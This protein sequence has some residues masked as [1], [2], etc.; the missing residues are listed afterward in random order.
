[1][2]KLDETRRKASTFDA[3]GE[4]YDMDTAL[5]A[6]LTQDTTGHWP[7]RDPRTGMILK[8]R[9]HETFP[10]TEEGEEAAGYRIIKRGDRYYS[11][12]AGTRNQ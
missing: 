2:S 4:G 5:A 3:E 1:M 10:L 12:P 7:S 9:T 8:G 11:V 6:G